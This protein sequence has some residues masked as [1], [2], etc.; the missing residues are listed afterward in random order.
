MT[1]K[2]PKTREAILQ[3]AFDWYGR[4]AD[5]TDPATKAEFELW[6]ADPEHAAAFDEIWKADHE[7]REY[8]QPGDYEGVARKQLAKGWGS[9]LHYAL[10]LAAAILL[11]AVA[12][13][14]TRGNPFTASATEAVMLKTNIGEIREVTLSDG[15][16]VTLDTSTKVEVE[17]SRSSRKAH[18]RYGRA[19]FNIAPSAAPFE[20]VTDD[21]QIVTA[22]GTI[23]VEHQDHEIRVDDLAGTAQLQSQEGE[24][25][26][27]TLASGRSAITSPHAPLQAFEVRAAPDWTKGMLQFAATPLGQVVEMANR[28]SDQRLLLDGNLAQLRVTGV[29]QAGDNA[30][31][32]KSLGLAFSLVVRQTPDGN[33]H[34]ANRPETKSTH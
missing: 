16:K 3:E 1:N 5:K 20:I 25:T 6:S 9:S 28:Y 29:F 14:L 24:A 26:Q 8:V 30:G 18:L 4:I 27:L 10:S 12:T 2:N 34:L 22:K 33:W 32:A 13:L 17:F 31:L 7:F 23:D 15:S 21:D 19:R 11:I